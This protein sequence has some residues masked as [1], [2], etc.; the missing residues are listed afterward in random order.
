MP[1]RS[2][3][4]TLPGPARRRTAAPPLRRT[5]HRQTGR[6][7]G[8]RDGPAPRAR[9]SPTRR[10]PTPSRRPGPS[11]TP[12]AG[13]ASQSGR[14]TRAILQSLSL[15]TS[16]PPSDGRDE[17]ATAV[18]VRADRSARSKQAR[19][20]DS[21]IRSIRNRYRV[22]PHASRCSQPCAIG[23]PLGTRW[24]PARSRH[25][26]HCGACATAAGTSNGW[27]RARARLGATQ[28]PNTSGSAFEHSRS[29][30]HGS[31]SSCAGGT[32]AH[33]CGSRWSRPGSTGWRPR[34]D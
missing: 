31:G 13:A 25:A 7:A 22:G 1:A 26:G 5:A 9:C 23:P 34:S 14:W 29:R 30:R 4:A 8:Q 11:P 16:G 20:F 21:G 27:A 33:R 32:S 17:S 6:T 10:L 19:L 15:G 24:R 12:G 28:P 3:R 2:E 18:I